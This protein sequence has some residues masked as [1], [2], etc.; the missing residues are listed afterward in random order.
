MDWSLL[1]CAANGHVTYAPQ[2]PGLR[3]RLSTATPA[4]TP[5]RCQRCGTFVTGPPGASGPAAGAPQVRR[6]KEL[7]SAFI[8][9]LFAIER[10]IRALVVA[11]VAYGLWRFA[12]SRVSVEQAF[13]RDLPA[14]RTLLREF[15]FNIGKSRLF[16]LIRHAFM[17][18]SRTL[19][20][21]A[22]GAAGYAVI[23]IIEGVGLWLAR[24]WGE[25]FAMVATSLGIP[26][27]LYDLTTKVTVLRLLAFA[28]NVALVAY[29]VITKRLLGVRG[30]KEAYEARLRSESILDTEAAAAETKARAPAE[31]HGPAESRAPAEAKDAAE[32]K[33]AAEAKDAAEAKAAARAGPQPAAAQAETAAAAAEPAAARDA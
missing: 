16:G 6:G 17:L 27:E 7:R 29:L 12:S 2:E 32:A 23:E 15:G 14:L 24:R 5:W 33:A 18:D 20:W 1:G 31:T 28:I 22:L 26:F 13:N 4:G 21:L 10:F 30:G 11:A 3:E 19:T 25:Y 9:R 8:L